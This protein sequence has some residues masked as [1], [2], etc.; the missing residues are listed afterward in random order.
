MHV[1]THLL[2]GWLIADE[3]RQ[4]HRDKA[5]VAWAS[6]VADADGLGIV[7]DVAN[8]VLGRAGTTYYE[9]YHHYLGHGLLGAVVTTAFT[10]AFAV[11]KRVT[12]VLALCAFHLHLLMDIL[13]SRGSNPIDI[14]PINYLAPF[15]RTPSIAW[16]GQWPLTGWQNT[17]ITTLLMLTCLVTATRRGRSPV[18]LFSRRADLEFV[19]VLRN[20]FSG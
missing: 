11:N 5:L 1:V 10:Y 8:D 2:T 9:A 3:T 4:M 18:A 16:S 15:S 17:A 7:V 19:K 6:V 20:R 14:W 13:G 12:A